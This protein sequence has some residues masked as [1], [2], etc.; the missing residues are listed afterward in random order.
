MSEE[1]N[2]RRQLFFELHRR[3]LDPCFDEE[4][5]WIGKDR[6]PAL[7][8][9]LI[10][11]VPFLL[12]DGAQRAKGNRIILASMPRICEFAPMAALQLLLHYRGFLDEK[13]IDFLVDYVASQADHFVDHIHS[14]WGMNYNQVSMGTFTMLAG[15]ELLGREDLIEEGL[16]NL[17][18]LRE[19][20]IRNGF[21][22][23]F[24]SSTYTP[25]AIA[26]FQEMVNLLQTPQAVELARQALRR[27]WLEV[28]CFWHQ[29][30]CG[31]GGPQSR[32]Y[33]PDSTGL[34]RGIHLLLYM[35]FGE[36]IALSPLSYYEDAPG[37]GYLDAPSFRQYHVIF[38]A[39]PDYQHPGEE[40]EDLLFEKKYPYRVRGS[41]ELAEEAVFT[42]QLASNGQLTKKRLTSW[43]WPCQQALL[44]AYMT[45]DYALGTSTGWWLDGGHSEL[46]FYSA[47]R[48]MQ[49]R[50]PEDK[51]TLF[52]RY[53]LND[54]T[55]GGEN[56]YPF[57]GRQS[58]G[59]CTY[60]EGTVFTAQMDN[61]AIYACQ[62]K[63]FERH[64][65]HQLRLA[66][67]IPAET[68]GLPDEVW[69]GQHKMKGFQGAFTEVKTIYLR[70]GR[71]FVALWPLLGRVF[72]TPYLVRL[73][74]ENGFAVISFYNY[75]G[76][77]RDFS[78]MEIVEAFNGF[79]A[80]AGSVAEGS[81]ESFRQRAL[82]GRVIDQ[83][84]LYIRRIRYIEPELQLS[85]EYSPHSLRYKHV[86]I[87]GR[88]ES[89]E[90]FFCSQI[91]ETRFPWFDKALEVPDPS[92]GDW[93][94]RIGRRKATGIA[95]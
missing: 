42:S 8:E 91:D 7:R 33:M 74:M 63:R 48:N 36:R 64:A 13:T 86:A 61:L 34:P 83:Y 1:Q 76:P 87:N 14:F 11:A 84:Y 92:Y 35:V 73:G 24:V 26:S 68:S 40:I 80:Q 45:E 44:R 10:H 49:V 67:A 70:F 21:S 85:L 79:V 93:F 43:N 95:E 94:E 81:F 77:P 20:L 2:A 88:N 17:W 62:P 69:Y 46:F 23:E 37:P 72:Q 12:G 75:Q 28:A 71:S 39:I 9:R 50:S 3:A 89:R 4:G 19:E 30:S 27:M 47:R 54:N 29:P 55:I 57:V 82:T 59:H 5:H 53:L 58:T 22:S 18:Q 51:V 25:I 41:V 66:L 38:Y 60:Q 56:I 78:E 32:A 16:A 6:P 15:G 90:R 65:I 31:F 52:A